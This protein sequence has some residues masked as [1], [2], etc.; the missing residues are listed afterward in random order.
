MWTQQ[1]LSSA[2]LY[3]NQT[4]LKKT[5]STCRYRI[6]STGITFQQHLFLFL[7]SRCFCHSAM[8]SFFCLSLVS[9]STYWVNTGGFPL[10]IKLKLLYLVLQMLQLTP[11]S[12]KLLL[13]EY[14]YI[15]KLNSV[16][17]YL[18]L[19]SYFSSIYIRLVS[20]AQ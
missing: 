9:L 19:W 3:I 20:I 5:R 12:L 10:Q 14:T 7:F 6:L 13:L 4:F 15:M 11:F 18:H 2:F 8:R 17:E 16:L 1:V